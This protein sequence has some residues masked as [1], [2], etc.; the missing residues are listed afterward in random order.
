MGSTLIN[1][2]EKVQKQKQNVKRHLFATDVPLKA[3]VN[4][5]CPQLNLFV[6][7]LFHK[8]AHPTYGVEKWIPA[9]YQGPKEDACDVDTHSMRT[10]GSDLLAF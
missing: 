6:G 1:N 7:L 9:G 4:T 5:F 3:Q 2:K 10:R 8:E